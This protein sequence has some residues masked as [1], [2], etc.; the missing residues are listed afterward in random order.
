VKTTVK[1]TEHL[2]STQMGQFTH[3]RSG[4]SVFLIKQAAMIPNDVAQHVRNVVGINYPTIPHRITS[5]R[6]SKEKQQKRQSSAILPKDLR[7]HYNVSAELTGSTAVSQGI[8]GLEGYF[9]EFALKAFIIYNDQ[10]YPP[11]NTL[12]IGGDQGFSQSIESDLDMQ[13][14]T[15]IGTKTPTTFVTI[16]TSESLYTWALLL[17]SSS[18]P[19]MVYSI[20]YG[21][22]EQDFTGYS[23]GVVSDTEGQMSKLVLR[24]V[25]V[26]AASGDEGAAGFSVACPM[27]TEKYCFSGNCTLKAPRC[28]QIL[29]QSWLGT[30]SF[31]PT[32]LSS[33]LEGME[34][35]VEIFISH[36]NQSCQVSIE[37]DEKE[38]VWFYSSCECEQLNYT[39][40]ENLSF[41]PFNLTQTLNWP[42][43]IA[44]YPATSQWVTAVGATE[45]N[46]AT[47]ETTASIEGISGITSGGGF[48]QFVSQPPW[49]N[50]SIPSYLENAGNLPPV[51]S[52]NV[53]GRGYPDISLLGHNYE[54]FGSILENEKIEI[55]EIT[56]DGTSASTPSLAGMITLINEMRSQVGKNQLGFLNPILYKMAQER[57]D[58]LTDITT[59]NNMGNEDYICQYGWSAAPGWD[60]ATGLGVPNFGVMADYM[61]NQVAGGGASTLNSWLDLFF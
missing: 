16:T 45:W 42:I 24:G 41:Y 61:V 20:S 43:F 39:I 17:S 23:S 59:G 29:V 25:S 8:F 6:I 58:A 1:N 40:S 60:P 33:D 52:Y 47:V 30:F 49:Q 15:G 50:S 56:V 36:Q 27:D 53:E 2:L 13:Y 7:S 3:G 28:A 37:T 11:I 21:F 12:N 4:R 31:P 55:V 35:D 19:A 44:S 5:N 14:I 18:N 38:R 9:S 10:T 22:S 46:S 26:L 57:P 32:D 48:S 51:G 54:V 34:N